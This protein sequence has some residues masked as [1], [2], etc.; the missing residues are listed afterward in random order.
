MFA[1]LVLWHAAIEGMRTSLCISAR[2]IL[3]SCTVHLIARQRHQIQFWNESSSTTGTLL[4]RNICFVSAATSVSDSG[5]REPAPVGI[6]R[7]NRSTRTCAQVRCCNFE[8]RELYGC[9]LGRTKSCSVRDTLVSNML[10]L[11]GFHV[12]HCYSRTSGC[13]PGCADLK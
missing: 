5:S 9:C 2:A 8:Q 4:P 10:M 7:H 12:R 3:W 6:P 13:K 11:T 1:S